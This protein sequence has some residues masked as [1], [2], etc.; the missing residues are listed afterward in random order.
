MPEVLDSFLNG[1]SGFDPVRGRIVRVMDDGATW[2]WDGRGWFLSPAV[3][4][5][6]F[7]IRQHHL[8]Y[9]GARAQMLL[10]RT[11][12]SGEGRLYSYEGMRW[13]RLPLPA[14]QTAV[15]LVFDPVRSRRILITVD[16]LQHSFSTWEDAG[17]G[18]FRVNTGTSLPFM[19]PYAILLDG[20]AVFDGATG[21]VMFVTN[22]GG[23]PAMWWYDGVNWTQQIMTLPPWR[24]GCG[25]AYDAARNVVVMHTKAVTSTQVSAD[26]W[27]WDGVQ[28][29]NVG[30][31]AGASVVA[32][33][34]AD[35]VDLMFDPALGGLLEV[36]PDS[37][38]APYVAKWDGSSWT[39][40]DRAQR[41]R[42]PGRLVHDW[43]RDATVRWS[44]TDTWEWRGARWVFGTRQQPPIEAAFFDPARGAVV[45]VS[46]SQGLWT[47]NGSSWSPLPAPAALPPPR[48][49]Y[50]LSFDPQRGRAVLFGGV[51]AGVD[52][53]DTWEWDGATWFLV[54]TTTA[55]SARHT[56]RMVRDVNGART[57][58]AGGQQQGANGSVTFLTDTWAY[59]GVTWSS[60]GGAAPWMSPAMSTGL[61]QPFDLVYDDL[62]NRT[63]AVGL[64]GQS[65]QFE[66]YELVGAAWQQRSSQFAPH[67]Q[68]LS[69]VF[70]R[71][72]G[73]IAFGHHGLM[74]LPVHQ[75]V[76]ATSGAGCGRPLQLV[77]RAWPRAGERNFGFDVQ[78]IVGAA[79]VAV[80]TGTANTPLGGNCTALLPSIDLAS[81]VLPN[82]A[83]FGTAL[84]PIPDAPLFRGLAVHAQAA[85]LDP[86][87]PIGV[88]LSARLDLVVGD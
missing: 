6:A 16:P 41:P 18:W 3:A 14:G 49:D 23:T 65:G 46:L 68:L 22:S 47:W 69:A 35:Q 12:G 83:G 79:V 62:T 39:I 11:Q 76:A 61:P 81:L 54:P 52:F 55:P 20:S 28:W 5:F 48:T 74:R 88:G 64:V 86:T 30:P 56:A 44:S 4:P 72:R 21:R 82:A 77:A 37:S 63:L 84:V 8:V 31:G 87:S 38:L 2:E 78:G 45:G 85:Q 51:A 27:E 26:V 19:W 60:L 57:V 50:A 33:I 42:E 34:A 53:A 71:Q 58:L 29:H 1:G 43:H 75:A 17:Q 73:T 70:E 40:L 59:D 32:T 24:D 25:L 9:D 15:N 36:A 13:T 7:D 80:S 10:L 67:A 66:V